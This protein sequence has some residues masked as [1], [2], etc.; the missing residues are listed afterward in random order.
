[1]DRD[2]ARRFLI[3]SSTYV[4]DETTLVRFSGAV[5][6]ACIVG[7]ITDDEFDEIGMFIKTMPALAG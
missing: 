3:A 2:E 7:V 4:R 6:F 5:T 1:M